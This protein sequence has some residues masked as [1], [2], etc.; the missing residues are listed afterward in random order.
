MHAWNLIYHRG[1]T[2]QEVGERSG[3]RDPAGQLGA[4]ALTDRG[5]A[6]GCSTLGVEA[7]HTEDPPYMV[8]GRSGHT[9]YTEL[10][11]S[12]QVRDGELS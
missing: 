2:K 9:L 11:T 3:V 1:G 8:G 4:P 10:L 7:R 6:S 12:Q 5:V